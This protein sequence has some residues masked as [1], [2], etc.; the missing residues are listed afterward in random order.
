MRL[1][2]LPEIAARALRAAGPSTPEKVTSP[3]AVKSVQDDASVGVATSIRATESPPFQ[4]DRIAEIRQAIKEDRYPLVPAQI[5]DAL[6]A[7]KL[8]RIAK[9]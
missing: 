2:G 4:A 7:A 3:A 6:I 5:A 9:P 8:Y 1:T